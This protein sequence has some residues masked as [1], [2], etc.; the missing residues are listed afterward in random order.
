MT[1][2]ARVAAACDILQGIL[3]GAPAEKTLTTWARKNRYAGSGDRAAIRDLVFD[4]LRKKRSLAW[5]GG[6]ESGRGLMIGHLRAEGTDPSS[7]F[8]GDGYAPSSLTQA[9]TAAHTSLESAPRPVRLDCPDWLFPMVEESLGEDA[10]NILLRL[11][12][13]A[14]LF[15]R[16]NLAR[17]DRDGAMKAL[18]DEAISTR[19]HRLSPTALEVT[20]NPRRVHDSQAFRNGLVEFQDVASQAVVDFLLNEAKGKTVLDYCAGGGGKSLALAAGGAAHVTAHDANPRRMKDIEKRSERAGVS[21]GLVDEPE[22]IFDV[23]LCDVPCSGSGAWSRQPDAKWRLTSTGLS[24]LNRIQNDIIRK[25][26]QHVG[27]NGVLAYATCS[28]L[29]AENEDRIA[30]FLEDFPEWQPVGQ[31]RFT[32]LDGG[33]GFYVAMMSRSERVYH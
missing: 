5:L 33:D 22:G 29:K 18:D 25:A 6:S 27:P 26:A 13:R 1:P 30:A 21:I 17:I 8:T 32:P 9:E 3:T 7:V 19:P 10:E 23:V 14:P 4:A 11:Q 16:V 15:L 12:D 31:R 24:E 2:Q 28:L 20:L